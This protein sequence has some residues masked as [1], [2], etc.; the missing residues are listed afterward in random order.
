[1]L[2]YVIDHAARQV[3]QDADDQ[4]PEADPAL[5]AALHEQMQTRP[6]CTPGDVLELA[7]DADPDAFTTDWNPR[8]VAAVLRRYGFRTQRTG[9]KRTYRETAARVADVAAR[10][11]YPIETTMTE[12]SDAS[13]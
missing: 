10:Y 4:F 7:T 3:E 6:R 1:M 5:L 8:R 9:G 13:H 11:G 2:D 12:A